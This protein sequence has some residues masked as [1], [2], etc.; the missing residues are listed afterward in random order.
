[1]NAR[2]KAMQKAKKDVFGEKISLLM[3]DLYEERYIKNEREKKVLLDRFMLA[4]RGKDIFLVN[5]FRE[6]I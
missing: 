5:K 3:A 1:M 2:K 6:N 4:T